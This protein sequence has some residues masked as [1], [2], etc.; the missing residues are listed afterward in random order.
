MD[1]SVDCLDGG[2]FALRGGGNGAAFGLDGGCAFIGGTLRAPLTAS[3]LYLEL[4][5]QFTNLFFVIFVIFLVSC[6]TELFHLTPFY[7]QALEEMTEAHNH[8][9]EPSISNF[10]LTVSDHAFVVGKAVR[11]I[12]WPHASVIVSI[13]HA[14]GDQPEMDDG[15]QRLHA[16][17]TVLLRARYYDKERILYQLRALVGTD[18]EISIE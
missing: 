11:D 12:M 16:G 4:T 9:K 17:D 1:F 14:Y 6:I 8:G 5:G 13:T 3:V 18:H 2:V 10:V 15:E 7:D